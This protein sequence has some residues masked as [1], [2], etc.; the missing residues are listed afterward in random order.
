M[1]TPP[2]I[3]PS[4][5]PLQYAHFEGAKNGIHTAGLDRDRLEIAR[6]NAVAWIN[7]NPGIEIVSIE[8]SFGNM[9]AIVTVWFR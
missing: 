3:P 9:L 2:P 5:R 1:T 8:S 6:K 4:S 7:Q